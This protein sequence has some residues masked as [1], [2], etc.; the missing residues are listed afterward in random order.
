[1]KR[2][3]NLYSRL[4]EP[5]NLR[6]AFR[7]AARGRRAEPEVLAFSQDL[8]ANL[9]RMADQFRRRKYRLGD[10]HFFVIRDPKVRTICAASFPERVF[11]H[12]VM[13]VCLTGPLPGRLTWAIGY[14]LATCG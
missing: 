3:R 7:K 2:A 6:E 4:A 12:A 1:M 11:H 13:N 5:E 14:S 9:E 8:T 10:Y